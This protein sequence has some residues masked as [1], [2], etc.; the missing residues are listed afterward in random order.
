MGL[1][2]RIFTLQT[3]F[4]S[5]KGNVDMRKA[6]IYMENINSLNQITGNSHILEIEAGS[7]ESD[8][9]E[10]IKILEIK[11]HSICKDW[12]WLTPSCIPDIN[13]KEL[14]SNHQFTFSDAIA[15]IH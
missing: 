12:S 8:L 7:S 6:L 14:Q 9:L 4:N 13:T 3:V 10:Q 1:D 2:C 15:E 11:T 5:L